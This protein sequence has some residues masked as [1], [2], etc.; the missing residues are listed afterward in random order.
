MYNIK[1]VHIT[2]ILVGAVS[3]VFLAPT[4]KIPFKECRFL[5]I[6]M[7]YMFQYVFIVF[8]IVDLQNHWLEAKAHDLKGEQ[9]GN[10]PD[11]TAAIIERTVCMELRKGTWYY[12]L[13]EYYCSSIACE[14]VCMFY[15]YRACK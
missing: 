9:V 5:K 8:P 7:S 12:Y 2:F 13:K 1:F 3:Y 11:S 10:G 4:I 6:G 14:C 15:V